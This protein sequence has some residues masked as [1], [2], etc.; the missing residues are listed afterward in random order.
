MN[1]TTIRILATFLVASVVHVAHA[2]LIVDAV[3]LD[4]A[5][6]S[7]PQHSRKPGDLFVPPGFNLLQAGTS[8]GLQGN[9]PS[10]A[11][12]NLNAASLGDDYISA[13]V[14]FSVDRL[15]LGRPGT[16][17]AAAVSMDS[18]AGAIFRSDF[19]MP[20]NS[21]SFTPQDLGLQAGFFGDDLN[22]LVGRVGSPPMAARYYFSID[23]LSASVVTTGNAL[24]DN[25]L[26]STATGTW[27]SFANG[28]VSMGLQ[29]GDDMDA[30]LLV[31]RGIVGTMEPGIDFAVFSLSPAS[32]S[33]FTASG[34]TY[35][36]GTA[37]RLSPADL[38]YTQFQ[39]T[40]QLYQP[41][42]QL[43]LFPADNV[44][45]LAVP[46]PGIFAMAWSLLLL[47]LYRTKPTTCC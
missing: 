43:G 22:A 11:Y 34:Q 47:L 32:P 5:S 27:S 39:G 13:A 29:A 15:T 4:P 8:L 2:Q 30:L 18:A 38:L 25:I 26:T 41:A 9:F 20:G 28:E 17:V 35:E 1:R 36:A 46:E 31:D 37:G 24:A 33:T 16:A 23:A 42:S 10:A 14:Y 6:P 3:S 21:L 44:N 45:A 19:A 40:F 12:D 7:L